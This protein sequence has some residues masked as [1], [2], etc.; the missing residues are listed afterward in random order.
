ML[1][2][3]PQERPSAPELLHSNAV[4][5]YLRVSPSYSYRLYLLVSQN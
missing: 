4:H 2:K 1:K 5:S 3:T